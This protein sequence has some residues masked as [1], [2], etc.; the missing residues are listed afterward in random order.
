MANSNPKSIAWWSKAGLGAVVLAVLLAGVGLV[1]A[2]R[3]TQAVPLKR[4]AELRPEAAELAQKI[5]AEITRQVRAPLRAAALN[6]AAVAGCD[7]SEPSGCPAWIT[8]MFVCDGH[9]P[10]KLFRPRGSP[11][12]VP[13]RKQLLEL[14]AARL[15]L[16]LPGRTRG[17]GEVQFLRETIDGRNV[18]VAHLAMQGTDGPVVIAGVLDADR[19]R[20]D[21]IDPLLAPYN[22]LTLASSSAQTQ[23]WSEPLVPVLP[24]LAVRPSDAFVLAQH[25]SAFRQ[26]LVYV[27]TMLLVLVALLMVMRATTRVARREMELSRLRSEF[28][29]DVSHELKTPL[30]LIQMFGETLLEGRVTSEEKKRE[31]YEIITRESKRLTHLINNIL[32]FSRLESGKKVYRM[33]RIRVE[34]TVRDVYENYRH[35]LD[36]KGFEHELIV[37]DGLPEVDADPGAL[38]QALLNLISNAIKYSDEERCLTVELAH[39]TRRG[40]RGVLISMRD[41]GIGIRPEDRARLFDGFFRAPDDKV[42][43]RRG[44]GLGLSLVRDIV[45]AHGGF[46]EVESRL[47]KGTTFHIFFPRSRGHNEDETDG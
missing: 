11:Q 6:L 23:A 26:T 33:Q 8:E 10:P 3:Q 37:A 7:F 13:A 39:E 2:I 5:N 24:F 44:A 45:E 20:R 35:E 27:G 25:R 47:V 43:K 40:C 28:V 41:R 31:Y 15:N 17:A 14:I 34:D 19:L 32:D 1:V 38:A 46:V 21:L 42:R 9:S 30:A 22:D 29:A 12:D 16:R 36:N 4:V 18:V